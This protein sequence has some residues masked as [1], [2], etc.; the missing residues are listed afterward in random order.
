MGYVIDFVGLINFF[1]DTSDAKLLLL[2]NNPDP[3]NPKIPLHFANIFVSK[4]QVFAADQ[5]PATPDDITDPLKVSRFAI[6]KPSTLTISGQERTGKGKLK[7][8]K[9]EDKLVERL[10]GMIKIVPDKANTIAKIPIN[11]GKLRQ[12]VL[13]RQSVMAQLTVKFNDL[14]TI[15]A[16]AD[17]GS[18]PPKRL[19]LADGSEIVISNT[20]QIDHKE[21][22]GEISHFFLY[23]QLDEKRD[24]SK[25]KEEPTKEGFDELASAHPYIERLRHGTGLIPLPGCSVT[26][27]CFCCDK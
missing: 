20:S 1:G 26:N 11:R 23:A 22:P 5:W 14:V 15:T 17:D 4:S 2:P 24:D 27:C 10:A 12:F 6:T 19:V 16:T 3:H 7:I 21:V 13:A 18:E 8:S 9:K 25:L